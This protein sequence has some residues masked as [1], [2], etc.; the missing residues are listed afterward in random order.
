MQWCKY[1]YN[2]GMKILTQFICLG[3]FDP[4]T[5]CKEILLLANTFRKVS[6]TYKQ[7][8]IQKKVRVKVNPNFYK[9]SI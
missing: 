1:Q 2:G 5:G 6:S 8:E 4:E 9:N 3:N 7:F